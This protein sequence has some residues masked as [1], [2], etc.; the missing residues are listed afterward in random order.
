MASACS[1]GATSGGPA[2]SAGAPGHH[3]PPPVLPEQ[4]A[5]TPYDGV[6]YDDPGV[7]PYVDPVEDRVST[8]A[9]DVDT[10]SYT[11]AQRY[12]DDGSMS[13]TSS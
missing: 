4:P 9:L 6:T 10:A 13:A 11:I 3:Q 2:A 7:N 12:I 5:A 1:G 8:F